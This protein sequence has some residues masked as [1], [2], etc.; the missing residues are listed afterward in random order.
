LN[1]I[2]R[3]YASYNVPRYTSYPTAADFTT[4]GAAKE[5]SAWLGELDASESASVYLHVP[6][7]RE[8]CLYCGC[9]TKMAVRDDVIDA[10]RRALEAEI[11]LVARLI[12]ERP[13]I[14]RLHWGGGT[15]S[16]LGPR[17][18]RSV[19]TAIRRQFSF[20]VGFEHAIE[21]DPRHVTPALAKVLGELGITRASLG[22][23]MSIRL[24]RLRSVVCSRSS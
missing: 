6:Y 9:N 18:L 14:A 8:I 2:V 21:L 20:D 7:C 15:P 10:Y 12:R 11:D 3:R 19:I 23:R 16:I 13:R 17:G 24:F 4:A 1:N 5:H 22:V